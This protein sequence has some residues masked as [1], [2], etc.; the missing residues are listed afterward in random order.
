[1]ADPGCWLRTSHQ[2]V[3]ARREA[4]SRA[5]DD[6]RLVRELMPADEDA[7]MRSARVGLAEPDPCRRL[8]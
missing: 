8:R 3:A 4:A 6:G 1:M 7:G 5:P 2:V